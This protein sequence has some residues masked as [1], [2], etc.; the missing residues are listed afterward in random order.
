LLAAARMNQL[1]AAARNGVLPECYTQ[2][3]PADVTT[4][5]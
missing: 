3:S 2:R 5:T 4:K 1:Q